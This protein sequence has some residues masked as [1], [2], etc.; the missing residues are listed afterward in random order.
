MTISFLG[1]YDLGAGSFSPAVT[2]VFNP[3]TNEVWV[4]TNSNANRTLRINAQTQTQN[5]NYSQGTSFIAAMSFVVG[6]TGASAIGWT[7]GGA[8]IDIT[9]VSSNY[10]T[11]SSHSGQAF[12]FGVNTAARNALY[13]HLS[14]CT[15]SGGDSTIT[16]YNALTNTFAEV[17]FTELRQASNNGSYIYVVLDKGDGNWLLGTDRMEIVEIDHNF[18]VV[19]IMALNNNPE[20]AGSYLNDTVYQTKITGLS[21]W[22]GFVMATDNSGTVWQV[23]WPSKQILTHE[24]WS[25]GQQYTG[26]ML[27]DSASGE[28][29]YHSY[30][31]NGTPQGSHGATVQVDFTQVGLPVTQAYYGPNGGRFNNEV[32]AYGA[33][34]QIY[35]AGGD[36]AKV[37]FFS[38]TPTRSYTNVNTSLLD[39]S[40]YR[41]GRVIR[42]IDTGASSTVVELDSTTT[43]TATNLYPTTTG[44]TVLEFAVYGD[45]TNEKGALSRYTT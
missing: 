5:S 14:I 11:A 44:K 12:N 15:Y 4:P 24:Q 39:N 22:D 35:A 31:A 9:E 43:H 2:A 1:S 18:N 16:T 25:N 17:S 41:A 29:F 32:V 10:H 42:L 7:Y 28:T 45:G 33:S 19:A 36:D 6:T 21:Y 26:V 30:N 40:Q 3:G 37:Y 27:S 38:Y 13:T 23:H 34:A 20:V 8:N